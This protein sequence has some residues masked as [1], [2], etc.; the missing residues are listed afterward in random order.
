MDGP[1]WPMQPVSGS[2]GSPVK[3]ASNFFQITCDPKENL[4]AYSLNFEPHFGAFDISAQREIEKQ[5]NDLLSDFTPIFRKGSRLY[6]RKQL[7]TV[8]RKVEVMVEGEVVVVTITIS[9]IESLS[10][11]NANSR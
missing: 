8:H 9:P 3:L 7:D 2:R 5:S 11:M 1:F 4:F 10:P 6:S